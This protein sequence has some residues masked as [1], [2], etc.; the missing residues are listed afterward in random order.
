MD[1][2]WNFLLAA[3]CACTF[4]CPVRWANETQHRSHAMHFSCQEPLDLLLDPRRTRTCEIH[5]PIWLL[6][7]TP[8]L[9]V[10]GGGSSVRSALTGAAIRVG[11]RGTATHNQQ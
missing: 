8:V 7:D 1:G 4:S 2:F 9:P 10:A 11:E 6:K 5:H 3:N